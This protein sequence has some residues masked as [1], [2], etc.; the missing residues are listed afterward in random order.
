V[1]RRISKR[2]GTADLFAVVKGSLGVLTDSLIA[3]IKEQG[4]VLHVGA[5][6]EK[7]EKNDRGFVV[8]TKEEEQF[9]ADRVLVTT[10][11]PAFVKM[12][13][14][15]DEDFIL[16]SRAIEYSGIINAVFT[17]KRPVSDY[18]WINV[19]R[20]GVPFLGIIQTTRLIDDAEKHL[21]YLPRYHPADHSDFEKDEAE[22]LDEYE[23]TLC[24]IFPDL[25]KEEILSKHLFRERLAD[26][27]YTLNYSE[28]IPPHKTSIPGLYCFN[29]TQIYPVTRSADSS[30]AFGGKAVTM[31]LSDEARNE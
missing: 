4:G 14:G 8:S 20:P 19:N 28:G 10:P 7:I 23:K 3:K 17:L 26:P 6:V 16:K 1:R 18:F 27:F 2:K 13:P 5:A 25:K 21:V 30:I 22:I 9:Q 24:D 11:L 31:I 29:T 12:T 15:L